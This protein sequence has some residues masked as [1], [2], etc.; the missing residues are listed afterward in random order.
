MVNRKS[1]VVLW[2]VELTKEGAVGI[3]D[4][5]AITEAILCF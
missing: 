3:S 2:F 1:L 5:G 4:G